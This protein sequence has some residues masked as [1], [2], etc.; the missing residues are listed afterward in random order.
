MPS[1][2]PAAN[3]PSWLRLPWIA[4][5]LDWLTSRERY[6]L[7]L[8]VTFQLVFLLTLIVRPLVTL[9]TGQTILLR[10]VPVDPRDMFRGDFVALNYEINRPGWGATKSQ[11]GKPIY[12]LLQP[13]EDG[14]HWRANGYQYDR[15]TEGT[16][17]RGTVMGYGRIQFGIEQFFVEEGTGHDYEKAAR[18]KKLSAE[19]AL[20]KNG[21]A[22]IKRLLI[23]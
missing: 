1:D 7:A 23:E 2:A 14:K 5:G 4:R 21:S 12:V 11:E 20:D 8:G 17:I 19:I 6:I 16:F 22:Q 18:E 13:E 10:V 15:P 3:V 9:S